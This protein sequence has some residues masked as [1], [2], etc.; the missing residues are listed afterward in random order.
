MAS[1]NANV[2]VSMAATEAND[3]E[4]I[5][6]EQDIAQGKSR[7]FFVGQRTGKEA[8][9]PVGPAACSVAVSVPGARI[10]VGAGL[11]GKTPIT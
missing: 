3:E 4:C 5:V 2:K 6:R 10:G 7:N 9:P 1:S 11:L 8:P